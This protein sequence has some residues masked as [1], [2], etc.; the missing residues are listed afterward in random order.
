MC[1]CLG[2][3][4]IFDAWFESSFHNIFHFSFPPFRDL[5]TDNE[6]KKLLQQLKR[7]QTVKDLTQ[8]LS[9]MP[10]SPPVEEK[11][12]RISESNMSGLISKAKEELAK[13]KN[14][15]EVKP[16]VEDLKKPEPKKSEIE[17]HWEELIK[18]MDRD[19][20]LCDLDFRDLTEDDE[21]NVMKPRGMNGSSIPPPPPPALIPN[22]TIPSL[23]V[24]P[25]APFRPSSNLNG[26]PLSSTPGN[27]ADDKTPK[28]TKKTVIN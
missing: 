7:E 9:N 2:A 24:A 18:N 3:L 10:L 16:P 13:N 15:A 19:L 23:P 28:K 12:N 6:D 20:T 11:P 26:N 5:D 8:K 27:D 22:G 4:E 21:V 25:I 17:M 1:C 14:K